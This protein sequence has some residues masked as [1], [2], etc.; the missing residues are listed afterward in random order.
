MEYRKL[1][2]TGLKVSRLSYGAWISFGFQIGLEEAKVLLGC[3]RAHGITFFDNA[4]VYA[5]GKAEEI[6]GQAIKELGWRRQDFVIST[7]IY[8][9]GNGPNDVGLSRKHLIEGTKASLRRL[10]MDYVDVLF[11]HR[12]DENTPIEETVRAM[13]FIINQGWALYWGTSMWP[14]H[15]IQEAWQIASQLK[16]IGP[17]VEQ[18]KYNL[19]ANE[20]VEVELLPLYAKC[21]LGLTTYSPLASGLLS[22]KYSK[23]CIPSDSRFALKEYQQIKNDSLIDD[24]LFKVDELKSVA[25][26]LGVTLPQLAIAWCSRNPNVSTVITG[27]TKESQIKENVKALEVLPLLT[28][29]VLNK[30][31]AIM[32]RTLAS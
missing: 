4:E 15:M 11:C 29:E 25:K 3:C 20:K 10:Q 18:P 32:A 28:A 9:G 31:E 14:I 26:D 1:G 8:N 16:M 17:H 22:G 6:M 23:D 27:A 2:A 5:G 7:K 13:N 21:G 24:K 30:I 12:P 19:F